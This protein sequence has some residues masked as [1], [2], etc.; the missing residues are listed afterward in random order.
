MQLLQRELA[1]ARP[2][3]PDGR[4]GPGTVGDAGRTADPRRRRVWAMSTVA[5]RVLAVSL[6]LVVHA[7]AE[8]PPTGQAEP[9][10]V[11][12][13]TTPPPAVGRT[14]SVAAGG[15]LQAALERA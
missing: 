6:F 10:R 8:P 2:G 5:T 7:G 11:R 9:P 1:G 3:P 14:L 13:D 4:A 15:D 12:L